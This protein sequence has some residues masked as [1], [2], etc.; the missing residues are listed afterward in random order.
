[1]G[2][3][4]RKQHFFLVFQSY[5]KIDDWSSL[6]GAGCFISWNINILSNK[7]E[8]TLIVIK[9]DIKIILCTSDGGHI[10]TENSTSLIWSGY[11]KTYSECYIKYLYRAL[12]YM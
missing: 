6:W 5:I 2:Q 12:L 7:I 1:M 4:I 3:Y 11:C 10:L 8:V 9:Q